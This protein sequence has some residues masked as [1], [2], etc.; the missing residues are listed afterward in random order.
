MISLIPRYIFNFLFFVL[1]QVLILNK[2]EFSGY[3][4]PYLY[5]IFILTLPFETPGWLLLMLAGLLGLSIDVFSNTMGMHMAASL[6]MAFLRP[7]ILVRFAPRENYEP[8]TL[9][10]PSYYGFGWFFKYA[11]I[12]V[13][14]HH[15]F[16][17]VVESF[18]IENFVTIMVKTA[19]STLF[20]LIIM[21]VTLL[22]TYQK[23]RRI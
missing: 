2:M 9:P 3:L 17:F 13:F 22:F 12:L 8:G 1:L 16:Y 4:N 6:F 7:F 10:L 23:K 18:S 15:L 21:G 19:G 5:V 14:I 11:A 20:T